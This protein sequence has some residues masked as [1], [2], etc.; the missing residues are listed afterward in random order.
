MIF[1]QVLGVFSYRGQKLLDEAAYW[2]YVFLGLMGANFVINL[3]QFGTLGISGERLTKRIREQSF[4]AMLKQDVK[5]FDDKKNGTGVLTS[6]LSEDPEKISLLTGPIMGNIF[7][8]IVSMTLAIIYAFYYSWQM[9]LVVLA[10]VPILA[11]SGILETQATW[12]MSNNPEVRKSY[13]KASQTACDA[14]A[15]IRTVKSLT[16]EEKMLDSYMGN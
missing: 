12:A 4:R 1:G 13:E 8:L 6:R 9:T 14:I 10:I 3:V 5:F 7:Q 15:N 11:L 16:A 2:A